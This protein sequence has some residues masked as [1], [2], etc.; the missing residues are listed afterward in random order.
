MSEPVAIDSPEDRGPGGVDHWVDLG[1]GT[2]F[3]CPPGF[4][5][6]RPVDGWD[7]IDLVAT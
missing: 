5:D 2:G 6:D 7:G 3:G 1:G 4:F